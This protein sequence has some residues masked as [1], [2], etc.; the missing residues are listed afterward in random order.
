M[1]HIHAGRSMGT[2]GSLQ[3]RRK[4]LITQNGPKIQFL[5]GIYQYSSF[6]PRIGA[7]LRCHIV[8]LQ[9]VD[10]TL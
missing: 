2:I 1:L 6:E 4:G 8:L 10:T 9:I 7:D 3:K 5:E